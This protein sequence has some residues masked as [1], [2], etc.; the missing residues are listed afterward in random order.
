MPQKK[1]KK[2]SAAMSALAG[3]ALWAA[4]AAVTALSFKVGGQEIGQTQLIQQVKEPAPVPIDTETL[5]SSMKNVDISE[6]SPNDSLLAVSK[7]NVPAAKLQ[8]VYNA[9]FSKSGIQIVSL[10]D[11]TLKCRSEAIV[12]LSEMFDA[13]YKETELRTI[14]ITRAYEPYTP[15]PE[16][17]YVTDENGQTTEVTADT[18]K[19]SEHNNGYSFDMEIYLKENDS[20]RE[21]TLEGQY[22]WFK[23]HSWEYGFIQ[24]YPQGAEQLTGK[25]SNEAHFRYVGKI[26]A[27]LIHDNSICFEQ[28]GSL[29]ESHTAENPVAFDGGIIVY[30]CR[31]TDEDRNVQV[32]VNTDGEIVPHEAYYFGK[33]QKTVLIAAQASADMFE[34]GSTQENNENDNG[35]A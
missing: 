27:K 33:G 7:G 13:F 34:A 8:P 24:R 9:V 35:G 1:R 11:S 22:S 19:C 29:M 16:P 28:L 10:A 2:H 3:A 31:L 30:M 4:I 6:L 12:P 5:K 20:R 26:A 18:E 17:E 23:K 15:P 14:M 25:P 21:L 32:P